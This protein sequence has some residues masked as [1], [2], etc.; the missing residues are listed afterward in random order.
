[1]GF[2]EFPFAVYICCY[3]DSVSL[4]PCPF[5]ALELMRVNPWFEAFFILLVLVHS[6]H[7]CVGKDVFR[8]Y[9][10]I[11]VIFR[12]LIIVWPS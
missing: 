3:N 5:N 9:N 10:N 1:M 12:P 4:V 8:Q 11:G 6:G 7:N 2:D